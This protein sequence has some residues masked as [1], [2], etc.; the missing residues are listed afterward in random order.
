MTSIRERREW[1]KAQRMRAKR[2]FLGIDQ[3]YTPSAR[4]W[5]EQLNCRRR[6]IPRL[7]NKGE[8]P[9]AAIAIRILALAADV[10]SGYTIPPCRV[11]AILPHGVS[12][13]RGVHWHSAG[14][15]W[16][17]VIRGKYAQYFPSEEHAAIAYNLKA[18]EIWGRCAYINQ[19][20]EVLDQTC[21]CCG[22]QSPFVFKME[23]RWDRGGG[24][25]RCRDC[26]VGLRWNYDRAFYADGKHLK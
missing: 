4:W 7:R 11:Q 5:A 15:L 21:E 1:V 16:R 6:T 17:C 14:D 12:R 10:R 3:F 23:W 25:T 24:G 22:L 8:V 13:F 26:A 2:Y 20:P 19:V 9:N 18:K